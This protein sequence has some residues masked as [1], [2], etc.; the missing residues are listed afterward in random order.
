MAIKYPSNFFTQPFAENGDKTIIKDAAAAK[1]RANLPDGFPKITA[2]PIREGGIA[3]NRLDFNGILYMLSS[4]AWW[5]QS[6]GM[7]KYNSTLDYEPP[8]IVF[9]QNKYWQCIKA[10]G[11]EEQKTPGTDAAYWKPLPQFLF[12]GYPVK[13]SGDATGTAT[14]GADGLTIP[15]DVE[16]AGKWKKAITVTFDGDVTG[17]LTF[18]G[19]AQ[20][21][22][23]NL[24]LKKKADGNPVGTVIMYYGNTAP[25]GYLVCDGSMFDE[26][27]YPLLKALLGKNTT[28]NLSNQFIRGAVSG[29]RNVGT[30]ETDAGREITGT[31]PGENQGGGKNGSRNYNNAFTGAFYISDHTDKHPGSHGGGDND[32]VQVTFAASKSWG[33]EHTA[34]EFRP[35]NT[36]LLFC[37]KHD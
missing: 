11:K 33:A 3:P 4:L 6:G 14:A 30:T 26:H 32:N 12:E 13:L 21:V 36:A 34:Y 20:S 5:E 16:Q 10:N 9:H 35:V 2:T 17:T 37:I 8:A 18:D 19:A 1:G 7:W 31:V 29:S 24:T 22:K 27:K 23:S 25:E 15:A 28:P